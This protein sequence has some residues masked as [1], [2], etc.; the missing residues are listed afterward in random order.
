MAGDA[1]LLEFFPAA[2]ILKRRLR[3]ESALFA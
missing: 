1:V 3:K 2:P